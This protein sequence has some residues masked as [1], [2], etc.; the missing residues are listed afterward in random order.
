MPRPGCA[1]APAPP[2]PACGT[3]ARAGRERPSAPPRRCPAA[4][5]DE[6]EEEERPGPG[7]P[8]AAARE[9]GLPG[10][11]CGR[12]R[13]GGGTRKQKPSREWSRAAAPAARRRRVGVPAAGWAAAA[14]AAGGDGR[15][16]EHG[17]RRRAPGGG[18][19]R[20]RR[21]GLPRAPEAAGGR[22][23]GARAARRRLRGSERRRLRKR[24][25]LRG[26]ER[27]GAR[28]ELGGPGPD[29]EPSPRAARRTG[30]HRAPQSPDFA[31]AAGRAGGGSWAPTGG[32]AG[33]AGGAPRRG[34]E[35]RDPRWDPGRPG[36]GR[37]GPAA[38]APRQ[39]AGLLLRVLRGER[40]AP[41]PHRG[42]ALAAR[43]AA[44]GPAGDG[45][46]RHPRLRPSPPAV[47]PHGPP[48]PRW[49]RQHRAGVLPGART[50][51]RA[52]PVGSSTLLWPGWGRGS[53]RA[54]H[55]ADVPGVPGRQAYQA[56]A[57][58]QEGRV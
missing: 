57:L 33:A 14:R 25:G 46:S 26:H 44:S 38:P 10:G 50:F 27:P 43:L 2:R 39:E 56:L 30:A 32:R 51:L 55:G 16:A 36:S 35:A 17:E 12:P 1:A 40:P 34:A 18:R 45:R 49:R 41:G 19:P 7:P 48:A 42:A 22:R 6:E 15:G 13:P 4:R 24:L 21:R 37:A 8:R 20:W 23:R 28:G 29:G 52:Q 9:H 11:S 58:L 47:P 5:E 31:T 54:P 3:G 53:L